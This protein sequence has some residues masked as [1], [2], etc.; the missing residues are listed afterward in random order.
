[1]A[2]STLYEVF[3]DPFYYGDFEYPVGSGK[4]YTGKHEPMITKDEY[5]RVQILLG[6]NGRPRP[7]QHDFPF[8]GLAKCGECQAMITAEEKWQIICPNCRNK[9]ASMNKDACPKCKTLIEEMDNPTIL[10]YIY[11][12][13]TKRRNPNCT[14]K[15]IEIS[16]WEKQV[17]EMLSKIEISPRFKDWAIKYINEQNEQEIKDRTLILHSH[18]LS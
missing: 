18:L 4:W 10:H 2:R 9:F 17:D 13:C 8:T 6:R 3:T 16:A 7:K 15:S 14:Q 11:Y 12:H 1:M 5:D